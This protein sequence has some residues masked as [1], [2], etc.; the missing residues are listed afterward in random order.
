MKQTAGENG[1]G[2]FEVHHEDMGGWV[3]VFTDHHANLP[4]DLPVFL[5]SALMDW[6]RQRPHLRLRCVVP[7][8]HDGN[9]IELHAWYDVHLLPPLAGPA[10]ATSNKG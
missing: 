4:G 6:F 8:Q 2:R 9:T 1:S 3:R 7:V 10:P 5:S